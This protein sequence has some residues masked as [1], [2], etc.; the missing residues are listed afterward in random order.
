M[1]EGLHAAHQ[2]V[3]AMQMNAR[4]RFFW[5]G[6]D[7]DLKNRRNQC[8]RCNEIA[9]SQPDEPM[10]LTQDP[11]LPYEQ[12]AVDFFTMNGSQLIVYTDR[13]SGWVEVAKVSSTAFP[14]VRKLM[15]KWFQTFGVPKE[16]SSDGGPPFNSHDY[17]EFL[18]QWG[19]KKRM[20]SAHY[21]QSN[22][23]A[24]AAVKS[25]KRCIGDCGSDDDMM[26]RAIMMHRNTP[27]RETK[28]SPAEMLFGIKLRDHLPNKFRPL[29]KE[30][31]QIQKSVEL[32]NAAKNQQ[33]EES[34]NSRRTL[35]P[36]DLGDR[37]SIQNQHGNKPRL[38]SNTGTI[39][40]VL[41]DRQ[42]RLLIDGSRRLTLRNRKFLRKINQQTPRNNVVV[43]N[44]AI[45]TLP[46]PVID[47]KNLISRS[48]NKTTAPISEVQLPRSTE[49]SE[50]APD[51]IEIN[52]PNNKETASIPTTPVQGLPTVL[53]QRTPATQTQKSPT[54]EN[55][56]QQEPSNGTVE[57]RRSKRSVK[58]PKR[59]IEEMR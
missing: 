58:K 39:V 5:P 6:I 38:W 23:R 31:R 22:G 25:M 41:P 32:H 33:M 3:A 26:T 40:E 11:D 21:P 59:L 43:N 17:N 47:E 1:I 14:V 34:S 2:G 53:P 12:V 13:L 19:I 36:L 49:S 29:R 45:P 24:E 50:H 16:I 10:I 8:N 57:P 20:S 35:L 15:L 44:V 37:V 18:K 30:W 42:Y 51:M 55:R 52:S 46:N 56:C 48:E 9:P 4:E 28:I 54:Q 27:N 7:T